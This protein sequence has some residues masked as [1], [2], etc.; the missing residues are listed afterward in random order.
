MSTVAA[1]SMIESH[2]FLTADLAESQRIPCLVERRVDARKSVR[3]RAK[4]TVPGKSV[5]PSHTMDLSC[6]GASVT[7]PF[8]LAQGQPCLIDL[9]LEACGAMS[10]F[11][12]AAE[13]RYCVQMG[14][15]RFRAG[16]RFGEIDPATS[17]L[18]ASAL[19][20]SGE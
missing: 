20:T 1:E 11:H 17:A 4:I 8:E 9:E 15:A 10:A 12:I 6:R 13:V 19:N 18:I 5:L 16:M 3:V 7:L 2:E 14:K